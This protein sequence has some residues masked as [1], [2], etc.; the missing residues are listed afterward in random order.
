MS[1]WQPELADRPRPIYRAIADALETDIQSGALDGGTQLPTQRELAHDLGLTVTTVTRAYAEAE[2]RG[3]I[4]SHVGRGTFVR[5]RTCLPHGAVDEAEL[6]DL[7][8]NAMMPRDHGAELGRAMDGLVARAG[9]DHVL[10]YQPFGGALRHRTIGADWIVRHQLAASPDRVLITAGAQHAMEVTFATITRRGDLVLTE[11]LTYT[12]MK[13]LAHH[14]GFHVRGLP[15]DAD[16]LCPEAFEAACRSGASALYTLPTLQNPTGVIMPLSRRQKIASIAERYGVAI[17]EDDSYGLYAE[18]E[19]SL[20]SLAPEQSYFITSVSKSLVP[21]VRL[22]YLHVPEGMADRVNAAIFA[23]T[24]MASPLS[25]EL[26]ATWIE[27]G[28][29]DR[30][31]AWKRGEVAIRQAMARRLLPSDLLGGHP[32]SPHLFLTVPA[33]W[34]APDFVAQARARGVRVSAGEE[35]VVGRAVAPHAVRICL[36][37]P[38]RSGLERALLTLADL[39]GAPPE[40]RFLTV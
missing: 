15:M 18:H 40:P 32:T 21:G 11:E 19:P 26:V 24:V 8:V 17:V 30:I 25:A 33:P 6:V 2:R 35:F 14:L 34:R 39:L 5:P 12:G 1:I 16:G 4:S 22:G 10:G 13:A 20:A 3:L 7:S 27:T 38:S 28:L 23:S 37:M 36:G 31:V 9:L 29:A